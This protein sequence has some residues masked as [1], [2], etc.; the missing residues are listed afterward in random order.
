MNGNLQI[1][2]SQ[3]WDGDVYITAMDSAGRKYCITQD[4]FGNVITRCRSG[5]MLIRSEDLPAE[6]QAL[7]AAGVPVAPCN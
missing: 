1:S 3:D 6:I 4:E 5:G 7:I 2:R